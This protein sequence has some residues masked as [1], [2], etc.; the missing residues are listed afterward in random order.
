M[1]KAVEEARSQRSGMVQTLD[2]Y[3]FIYGVVKHYFETFE[4]FEKQSARPVVQV[5]D[6]IYFLILC[7]YENFLKLNSLQKG[8]QLY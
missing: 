2:Q 8:G 1:R 4:T 7:F 6:I 5:S 3:R